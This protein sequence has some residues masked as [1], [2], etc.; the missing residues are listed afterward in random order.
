MVTIVDY[1]AGNLTSVYRALKHIGVSAQISND[2]Q[3]IASAERIIFPGVGHAK[4]AMASLKQKGIDAALKNAFDKKIPIL[5]ICLGTQIIL[6]RSQEGGVD[7]LGLIDGE[8]VKFNLTDKTLK[9]PHM[10]WNNIKIRQKHFIL[11]DLQD[12]DEMYFVHSYYP[13]LPQ[14]NVYAESVHGIKFACAI[15]CKNLFAVQFHPEKSGESGLKILK[16]F[17][18]WSG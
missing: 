6:S 2:P 1:D 5:G 13:V 7:T 12:N 3:K 16:N 14:K 15:G 11:K 4:S 8:C 17:S 9:I 10:G 18:L